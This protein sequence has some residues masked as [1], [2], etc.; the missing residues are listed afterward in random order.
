MWRY[1]P[2]VVNG[3][4]YVRIEQWAGPFNVQ[5]GIVQVVQ[6]VGSLRSVTSDAA[7]PLWDGQLLQ[8]NLT[9][10]L[11]LLTLF[12]EMCN[13]GMLWNSLG[14]RVIQSS[15]LNRFVDRFLLLQKQGGSKLLAWGKHCPMFIFRVVLGE[16]ISLLIYEKNE[17][18]CWKKPAEE[19]WVSWSW[20]LVLP[21]SLPHL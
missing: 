21:K 6:D 11:Y 4:Q 3:V 13:E 5:T 14:H 17:I 19:I 1:L 7:C 8:H 2:W 15:M 18:E 9:F 16:K 12:E 10:K 20:D